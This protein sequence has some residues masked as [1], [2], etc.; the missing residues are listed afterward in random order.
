MSVRGESHRTTGVRRALS[1]KAAGT[2]GTRASDLSLVLAPARI[3]SGGSAT[4]ET[5]HLMK[6]G[7]AL[8]KSELVEA[9]IKARGGD[10][11]LNC[12][13]LGQSCESYPAGTAFTVTAWTDG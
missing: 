13:V 1:V 10:S 3:A 8:E 9:V 2:L 7:V 6:S 4:R 11:G 12:A 5:Q